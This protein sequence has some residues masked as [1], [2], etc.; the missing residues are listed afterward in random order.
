MALYTHCASHSLNL[1]VMKSLEVQSVRNM[2]GVVNRISIFFHAHPKRQRKLEDAVDDTTPASSVR[3]LKDMCR[4]RWVEPI[5]ALQRFKKLYSSVVS[6]FE[7]ISS[8]R[9]AWSRD[10]LSDASTLLQAITSTEFV[11][12]LVI[13]SNSL[14]CLLPLTKSL[15]AEARI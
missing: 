6:C 4:T 7:A 5:D 10:S 12:A 14:S 11:S 9:T 3:K 13:T 1:A 15:Q 8:E 2:I